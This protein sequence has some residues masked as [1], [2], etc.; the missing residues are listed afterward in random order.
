M[1]V[2][3]K[4][5]VDSPFAHPSQP[6]ETF[7]CVSLV[8]H[9]YDELGWSLPWSEIVEACGDP[10]EIDLDWWKDETQPNYFEAATNIACDKIEPSELYA[11]DL[12]LFRLIGTDRP[13]HAAVSV[14]GSQ[15][16]HVLA[17]AK[18][19]CPRLHTYYEKML[20]GTYRIK[21]AFR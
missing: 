11:G 18:V 4:A 6:P 12:L 15:F 19:Q 8:K 7:D 5:V 21:E 2:I 10:S 9:I 14:D 1:K 16:V 13:T 20:Y 3:A 17:N